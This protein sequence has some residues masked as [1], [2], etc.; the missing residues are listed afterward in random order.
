MFNLECPV[1]EDVFPN[2]NRTW[3]KDDMLIYRELNGRDPAIEN[4]FFMT[5]GRQLLM[6]TNPVA[7]QINPLNL[8][9]LQINTM[10]NNV[11]LPPPG[12]NQMNFMD[13]AFDLLLG[14]YTCEVDN[15][16]GSDTAS[17]VVRECGE[18]S[19]TV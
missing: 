11:T 9:Q 8:E 19:E 15:V 14:T 16:F 7:F 5:G 1:V 18:L 13:I 10:L 3:M 2:F 4:E 12:V 6:R 17:I